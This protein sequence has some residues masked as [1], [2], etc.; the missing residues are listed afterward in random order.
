[1]ERVKKLQMTT[2][3]KLFSKLLKKWLDRNVSMKKKTKKNINEKEG[4]NV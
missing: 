3:E 4:K 2:W 1:M